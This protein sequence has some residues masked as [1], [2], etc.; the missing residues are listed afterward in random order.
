MFVNETWLHN[1]IEE[2]ELFPHLNQ[3][4]IDRN[5]TK[6]GDHGGILV[7]IDKNYRLKVIHKVHYGNF[8]CACLL[9]HG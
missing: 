3:R 1:D 5:D 4:L 6:S 9:H 7:A 8:S 2:D